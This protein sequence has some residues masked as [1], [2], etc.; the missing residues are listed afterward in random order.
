MTNP[1]IRIHDLATGEII[2]REITD[3]EIAQ[4]NYVPPKLAKEYADF[5]KKK[6]ADKI[7][8]SKLLDRLGI[9][10]D[11]AQLLLG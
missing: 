3:E 11:E 2:D 9:T 1:M 8:K 5:N 6:E 7:A 10:A 4:K